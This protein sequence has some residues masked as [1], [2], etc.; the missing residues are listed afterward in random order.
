L[1]VLLLVMPIT[2]LSGTWNMR[3]SMP[4]WLQAAIY[5]SPLR[6]FV[7]IAYGVLLKGAGA[8]AVAAPAALMTLLGLAFLV[9][10][11]ARFRRQFR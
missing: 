7:D 6:Y 8:A 4:G 9:L 3:E 2:M 11:T 5:L 10:G 1:I